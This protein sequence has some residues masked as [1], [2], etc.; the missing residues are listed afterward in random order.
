MRRLLCAIL[1]AVILLAGNAQAA[2]CVRMDDGAALLDRDGGEIVS[3]GTHADIVA[4]GGDL[5]A[6]CGEDGLYALMDETGALRH[7][8]DLDRSN[9]GVT[10]IVF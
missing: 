7:D 5:Y 9:N 1:L 3:P 2:L 8:R 10:I 6:A 4:L